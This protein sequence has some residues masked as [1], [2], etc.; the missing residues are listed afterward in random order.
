LLFNTGLVI[1]R[2][3][4]RGFACEVQYFSWGIAGMDIN[5]GLPNFMQSYFNGLEPASCSEAGCRL[6]T[7]EIL[8]NPT[9]GAVRF[10][11]GGACSAVFEL[12]VVNAIGQQMGKVL[13][14]ISIEDEVDVSWLAAGIYIFILSFEDKPPVKK[15]VIKF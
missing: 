8:P 4:G 15:K 11:G 5:A 6:D 10:R 7:V 2:P 1:N 9:V 13:E 3:N 12:R 14:K